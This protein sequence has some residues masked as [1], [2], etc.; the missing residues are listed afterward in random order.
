MNYQTL[1]SKG[2]FAEKN[3]KVNVSGAFSLTLRGKQYASFEGAQVGQTIEVTS[4]TIW[5]TQFNDIK[6]YA[7]KAGSSFTVSR[8]GLV[9]IG[10]LGGD[11]A[12]IRV[13]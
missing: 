11:Q 12:S 9:L 8:P 3:S 1:A 4:G 2:K 7:I 5:L 6:D 10:V 13:L